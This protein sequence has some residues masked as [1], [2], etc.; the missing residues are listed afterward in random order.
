MIDRT[1]IDDV[2]DQLRNI[3]APL[4]A[5]IEQ[6]IPITQNHYDQYMVAIAQ[7]AEKLS[8]SERNKAVYIGVGI[9]MQ[10]AGGNRA[11]IMAALK[12]LGKI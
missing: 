5:E 7:V 6:S 2:L 4:V 9:A 10:R 11:G 1:N 12:A 8:R 3:V